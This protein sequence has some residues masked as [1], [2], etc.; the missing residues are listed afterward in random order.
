MNSYYFAPRGEQNIVTSM[1]VCFFFIHLS[2]HS[3]I[4]ETTQQNFTKFVMHVAYGHGSVLLCPLWYYV[5]PF[6][7][8]GWRYIFAVG[9]MV[10]HVYSQWR[11]HDSL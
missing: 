11:E 4:S 7:F 5:M 10:C 3:H 9:C 8:C 2:V 6:W 1:S